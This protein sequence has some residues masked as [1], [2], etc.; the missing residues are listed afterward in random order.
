MRKF[1]LIDVEN[2]VES[3]YDVMHYQ[4][5]IKV[6][7]NFNESQDE[8]L[9]RFILMGVHEI[10]FNAV[11]TRESLEFATIAD[12]NYLS[13]IV[14]FVNNEYSV[15]GVYFKDLIPLEHN[16]LEDS[17]VIARTLG[18]PFTVDDRN[19]FIASNPL[20]MI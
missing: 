18:L 2:R 15:D 1:K 13:A 20:R 7:F 6:G 4:N 11:E 3:L 8:N 12:K 17:Q 19:V 9:M 10:A 5:R 14:N 16:I